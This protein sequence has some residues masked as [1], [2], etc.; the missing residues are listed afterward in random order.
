MLPLYYRMFV[1]LFIYFLAVKLH[2]LCLD[3][4]CMQN[5][6]DEYTEA[7]KQIENLTTEKNLLLQ[8]NTDLLAAADTHQKA[9]DHIKSELEGNCNIRNFGKT[10]EEN[11]SLKQQNKELL[12]DN[13]DMHSSYVLSQHNLKEAHKTITHFTEKTNV[14][15]ITKESL[16]QDS[17]KKELTDIYY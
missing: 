3:I 6:T 5:N 9:Y 14:S 16:Q 17:P 1:F 15:V 13:A 8:Q 12:R 11:I 4:F 10:M 7:L 2:I